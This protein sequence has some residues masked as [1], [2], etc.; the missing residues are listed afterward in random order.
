[1]CGSTLKAM[2]GSEGMLPQES[3]LSFRASD[4]TSGAFVGQ[5][6]MNM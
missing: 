4:V 1:M 3:L 5:Q 2:Q 6:F